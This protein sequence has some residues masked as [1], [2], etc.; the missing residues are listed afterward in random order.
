MTFENLSSPA[1]QIISQTWDFGDGT[2]H[3][4]QQSPSHTY[5]TN[6]TYTVVLKVT[7]AAGDAFG[8]LSNTELRWRTVKDS[9]GKDV[10]I[11]TSSY[12][13]AL[14]SKDRR[15]RRDAFLALHNSMVVA[16]VRFS[17]DGRHLLT[18]GGDRTAAG[19][20]RRGRSP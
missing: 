1:S 12:S 3:G 4:T 13:R 5:G 15:Y 7:D 11:T 17:P 16:E 10:E 2:A 19:S 9:E 18:A 6:G 8:L 20:A 14:Q